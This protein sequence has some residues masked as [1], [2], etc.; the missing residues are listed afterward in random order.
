MPSKIFIARKEK[1][2]LGFIASKD[3]LTLLLGI[4][5]VGGLN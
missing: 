3:K 5:V 2:M 4:N 1:P